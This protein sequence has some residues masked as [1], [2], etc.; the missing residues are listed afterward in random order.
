[1]AFHLVALTVVVTPVVF[2]SG[3]RDWQAKFGGAPGGV[4]YKKIMLALIMLI[5]GIAAVTLRG[6][7][8]SWD[9]LELWGQIVYLSLVAGMLGCVTMLGHYG[10]QLVFKN[11]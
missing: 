6:V 2:I 7:V 10:G 11:H 9:G 5:L 4:F 3:L 1:T 8:G